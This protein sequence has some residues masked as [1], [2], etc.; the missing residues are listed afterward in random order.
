MDEDNECELCGLVFPSTL[1]FENHRQK[2]CVGSTLHLKLVA[3]HAEVADALD[4]AAVAAFVTGQ[5]HDGQGSLP[6]GS[7][8]LEKMSV[9][10]LRKR[11]V[12][13][14]ARLEES[15]RQAAETTA[16]AA[17][18]VREQRVKAE[19]QQHETEAQLKDQ[20]AAET[21]AQPPI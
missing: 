6:G 2:F 16:R 12:A 7:K 20:R 21:Q 13:D 5:P 10:T 3:K 19:I 11:M 17:A 4:P 14:S 15:R 1:A 9:G 18:Q 8:G